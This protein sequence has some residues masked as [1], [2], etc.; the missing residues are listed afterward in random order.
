MSVSEK[1]GY[2]TGKKFTEG[3]KRRMS[4]AKIGN[5][6]P[7]YGKTHSS[8]TRRKISESKKGKKK[9]EEH[10][11]KISAA[12]QGISLE[13]WMGYTSFAPYC[14]LFDFELKE[15]IRN[16]DGRKCVLCG[17]SEILNGRR[18]SVHH[19]NGDKMQGCNGKP[20]YLCT[21]CQSCNTKTDTLEK[22]F[23]IVANSSQ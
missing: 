3:H 2:W 18:L 4:E 15:K 14:H 12:R 5:R 17:K 1:A 20:W 10:K 9:S 11:Q 21:L 8:E 6:H 13:E 23:L 7:L 19:I 22:E 16:R